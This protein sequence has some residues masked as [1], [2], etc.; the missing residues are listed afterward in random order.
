MPPSHS[1]P[2]GL[3]AALE[4]T[5]FEASQRD[6]AS[7]NAAGVPL[8]QLPHGMQVRP[9]KVHEDDRGEVMEMLDVRWQWHPDPV[10]FTYY[11]TIRPGWAKGWGMHLKHEDRY[12]LLR[13]VSRLVLFDS[14]TDSPTHGLVSEIILSERT[15][16]IVNIPA[17]VWHAD[18]NIGETE[19]LVINF[20]TICYDHADPDKYRL[21]LHTDLIPYK[22]GPHVHGY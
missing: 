20:P 10:P 21:P 1:N 4:I 17:G 14:R 18:Q 9:L 12:C 16:Q 19:V 3:P 22:F 6:H 13:G 5:L 2:V 7:V 15:H 11:F 8:R